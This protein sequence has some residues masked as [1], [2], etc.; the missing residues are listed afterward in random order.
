MASFAI[1]D[2]MIETL[3]LKGH[4]LLAFALVHGCTQKGEG[5]WYGGYDKLAQRIGS[6]ARTITTVIGELESAGLIEV[7]EEFLKGKKRKVLH[8]KYTVEKISPEKISTD[9]VKKFLPSLNI[10][11]TNQNIDNNKKDKKNYSEIV[12]RIY[13]LYPA[14]DPITKRSTSKSKAD[15]V[16]IANL[17]KEMAPE[18]LEYTIK[19]YVEE[20]AQSKS[21]IPNFSKF[22]KH[23]P[24]YDDDREPTPEEKKAENDRLM[25]EH[26]AMVRNQNIGLFDE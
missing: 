5:C 18:K 4:N 3:R 17:L 15:K 16:T 14:S 13:K 11:N 24:D 2:W 25:E 1:E 6:T 8:S 22:L 20:N 10:D 21:W 23:L 12:D 26:L 7:T 19:R 9:G